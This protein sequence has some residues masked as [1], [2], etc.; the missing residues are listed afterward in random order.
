[1]VGHLHRTLLGQTDAAGLHVAPR[2]SWLDDNPEN[3]EGASCQMRV[4]S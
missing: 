2:I 3:V 4:R 1:M